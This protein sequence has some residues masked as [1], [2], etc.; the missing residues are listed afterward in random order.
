MDPSG[1]YV[2]ECCVRVE[3]GGNSKLVQQATG[4]LLAFKKQVEG[5]IELSVPERLG[6]DT[7]VK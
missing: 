5:A 3:D 6:L 4:E 2:L 1:A 7:R